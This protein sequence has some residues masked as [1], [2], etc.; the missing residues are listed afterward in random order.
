M[1]KSNT[2]YEVLTNN[3][4]FKPFI[5]IQKITKNDSVYLYTEHHHLKCSL[6]HKVQTLDSGFKYVKDLIPYVDKV[7]VN[8][9][10]GYETIIFINVIEDE[11][12]EYYDMVGV[13]GSTYATNC[14]ISH[15][16][17]FLS[18]GDNVIDPQILMKISAD[19]KSP[20][21]VGAFDGNLWYWGNSEPGREYLICGDVARGDATDYSTAHVID[22][23]AGEQ[24]AEYR[25]KV[26]P[27]IFAAFLTKLGYEF[28]EALIACEANSIGYATCLK[29]VELKYPKIFRSLPSQFRSVDRV[30]LE[31]DMSDPEKMIPGFQTTQTTRP[32]LVSRLEESL[33][34]R[35][36]II[37]SSRFYNELTTFI[38]LNGKPQGMPGYNDDLCM[39]M[40]IGQLI[41]ATTLQE[42]VNSREADIA[43][44]DAYTYIMNTDSNAPLNVTEATNRSPWIKSVGKG[45]DTEDLSWL[46]GR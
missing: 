45:N 40:G 24:V 4:E 15:N 6:K 42:Y 7:E 3:N 41:I 37:H 26:P 9:V 25:G 16:C 11:E 35:T 44:M 33:R 30:K 43:M 21:K 22:L 17:D 1:F 39:A 38:W 19:I 29:L 27:D 13:S 34:K 32:L 20:N 8:T 10:D 23:A 46:L 31:N 18:S 14:I 12:S 5:G 2:Q 28:N 36:L